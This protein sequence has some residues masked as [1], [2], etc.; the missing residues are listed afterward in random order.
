MS[1]KYKFSR[2]WKMFCESTAVHGLIYIYKTKL[3]TKAVWIMVWFLMFFFA[4]YFTMRSIY[5]Y[6]HYN[7]KTTMVYNTVPEIEFP[8]ITLC[9]QFFLR[10]KARNEPIL[11]MTHIM[12][13]NPRLEIFAKIL[14]EVHCIAVFLIVNCTTITKML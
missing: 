14:S 1:E 6:Y 11:L 10:N 9:N 3:P 2:I 7:V 5:Q 8:A 4:Y 12:E 13:Y